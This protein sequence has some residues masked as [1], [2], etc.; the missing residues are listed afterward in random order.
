MNLKSFVIRTD[1]GIFTV[2]NLQTIEKVVYKPRATMRDNRWGEICYQGYS[3]ET[4]YHYSDD[5]SKVYQNILVARHGSTEVVLA[6][7]P[8][9]ETGRLMEGYI[10][11]TIVRNPKVRMI[12][13]TNFQSNWVAKA[14]MLQDQ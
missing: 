4:K 2:T 3:D 9:E 12:D 10:W 13:L 11:D 6:E 8:D 7:L 5:L 1:K 14:L